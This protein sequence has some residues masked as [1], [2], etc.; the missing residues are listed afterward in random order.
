MSLFDSAPLPS[1]P[2]E[3]RPLAERMRPRRFDELV[4]QESEPAGYETECDN[5]EYGGYAFKYGTFR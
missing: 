3:K 2:D 5:Q 4:G 1:T